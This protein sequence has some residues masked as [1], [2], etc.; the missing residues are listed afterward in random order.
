M[1]GPSPAGDLSQRLAQNVEA[2]CRTYLSNGRRAGGYWVVGDAENHPG[3]SLFVR[4]HGPDSGKGAAGKWTDAATGDHGDLLDLI[5][6]NRHLDRLRD[7]LEEA[8]SFLS[9]PHPAPEPSA[10]VRRGPAPQGSAESARRLFAASRSLRG[11]LAD[12][13]LQGRCLQEVTTLP[14]LRFHPRCFYRSE[15]GTRNLSFPALIAAVT[16]LAGGVTGV[17]RT[18]LDP[19]GGKA[20]VETPRR[21]MGHLLGHAVRFGT[22]DA[23]LAAG[24]GLETVLS[25][26]AAFPALP[27]AAALSSN[28]LAAIL[29]PASLR[30]LYILRD[31]DPAGDAAMEALSARA[32][33]AGI[34]PLSLSPQLGDFNDDLCRL[35]LEA[36]RA[37]L[38]P[39]LV[40][41][42]EARFAASVGLVG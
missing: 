11:T 20:P 40:P 42:D 18:W 1:S 22:P 12:A 14:A 7:V 8:R 6:R 32:Q 19:A 2:V 24:E 39:Q 16:D 13:Y 23:V 28:H 33:A 36:L 4:L 3:S 25:V 10:H 15:D 38:L 31:A 30:V 21:A 27:L 17:H 37:H 5:A 35:G 29:F 34:T 9:L 26:R 41:G